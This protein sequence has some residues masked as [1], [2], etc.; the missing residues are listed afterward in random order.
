MA[1]NVTTPV[2]LHLIF[3]IKK[4]LNDLIRDLKLSVTHGE[5]LISRLK[6]WNL[7]DSS[8]HITTQ[9]DRSSDF[10][11]FFTFE[12]D[13]CFCLDIAGLFSAI[14]VQFNEDEWRLFI[15][16]SRKS[17]KAILLHNGNIRPSIPVAHSRHL[18]EQYEHI[19]QLLK[20]IKYN[21]YLSELLRDMKMVAILLGLQGGNTRFPCYLC[22]WD[23][24]ARDEH[25]S[26]KQWPKCIEYTLD[27]TH[28]VIRKALVI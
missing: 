23:S 28:N 26:N 24:Q 10:A 27:K 15:D 17:L 20:N 18:K 21:E 1:V 4:D 5:L 13:M 22:L 8:I 9:R 6:G 16:G 14:G 3:L 2:N 12:N 25:Y 11:K 7:V 19:A